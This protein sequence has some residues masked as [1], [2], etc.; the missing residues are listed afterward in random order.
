[1]KQVFLIL[2]FLIIASLA[3]A[4]QAQEKIPP[5]PI[6]EGILI[7]EI[8]E[9]MDIT[10][11]AIRYVLNDG[12]CLDKNYEVDKNFIN[13]P[14]C[15]ALIYDAQDDGLASPRQLFAM[16]IE[17]SE[18]LQITNTD[19]THIIGQVVS[20]TVLMTLAVC[21]DTDGN[22]KIN[23]K[24][25]PELYLLN[26]STKKM[27][28]LTCEYDLT[29]INN[30][31]YS[32]ITQKVIFSAQHSSVFHN[33]LFAIDAE[34]N[35]VQ[36]T[37]HLDYMDF[38]CAWSEDGTMIVFNRLPTPWLEAPSQIWLM[39]ADGSNQAQITSGG[40]NPNNEENQGPYPIGLDADPD[41]SPDNQKIVFSRLKT[42]KENIIFG[43]Y[44]LIVID[45]DT[46][47]IEIL[48]SQYANMVPQWKDGGILI[49]RQVGVGAGENLTGMGIKQSLYLYKDGFFTELEEYPFNVFP[50]GA[51]GGYWIERE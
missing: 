38:D 39:N 42:G 33:H 8:P 19:C 32:P 2:A 9:R 49:N 3:C 30:A 10:F 21:A 50:L 41:L 11:D 16:D 40:T 24:D 35:L 34:K 18:V 23:E 22:G 28:C 5:T 17:T 36:I 7:H 43:V 37:E 26:L 31:D 4:S 51:Y 15:N 1:M 48:D 25:K 45:V 29:S 44:E 27:N 20:P 47:E 13:L 14:D 46:K 6:P 12:A